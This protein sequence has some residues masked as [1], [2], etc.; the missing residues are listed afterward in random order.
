MTRQTW[1]LLYRRQRA[2]RDL[3]ELVEV[4]R[5]TRTTD[6]AGGWTEVYA[7][8]ATSPGRVDGL[9]EGAALIAERLGQKASAT[10]VLPHDVA[11]IAGDELRIGSARFSYVGSDAGASHPVTLSVVVAE[12]R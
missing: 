10:V 12:A 3:P 6:A 1:S 7:R 4:W 2:R 8:V 5:P 9:T 11:V